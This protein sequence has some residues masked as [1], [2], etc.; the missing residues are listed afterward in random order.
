MKSELRIEGVVDGRAV[1]AAFQ[2]LAHA[3]GQMGISFRDAAEAMNS[4]GRSGRS[5]NEHELAPHRSGRAFLF[6]LGERAVSSRRWLNVGR[7]QPKFASGGIVQRA[8]TF[9]D[10]NS[11]CP[12]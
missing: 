3:F 6:P 10:P 9:A 12:I 4:F 1:D 2:R 11:R 7:H 8:A 5:W